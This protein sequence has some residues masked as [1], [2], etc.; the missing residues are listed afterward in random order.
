MNEKKSIWRRVFNSRR[1]NGLHNF[2]QLP[3]LTELLKHICGMEIQS[4]EMQEDPK[5]YNYSAF[6]RR[7]SHLDRLDSVPLPAL[8]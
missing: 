5:T 6:L 2:N 4:K 7:A 8:C 3:G 1:G